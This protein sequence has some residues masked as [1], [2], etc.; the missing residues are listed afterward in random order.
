MSS[1]PTSPVR[2]LLALAILATAPACR[3]GADAA[4]ADELRQEMKALRG[5]IE[6]LNENFRRAFGTRPAAEAA[7]PPREDFDRVYSIDLAGSPVLGDPDAPVAIVEYS[8]FQCPYCARL[9]PLLE[10]VLQKYP[11]QVKLVFKHFPL[12][13]HRNARPAAQASLA[14][15]EQGKFWELHDLLFEN[16]KALDPPQIE[17]YAEQ[18]GLDIERFRRDLADNRAAYDERID[19]DLAQGQGVDV[20]G[21]PTVYIAGRKL[22]DRSV[23]GMSA[24]VERALSE[25]G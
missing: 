25:S 4:E 12:S 23:D 8:D 20:R 5:E 7:E 17:R 24:L 10:E 16:Q 2:L 11:R 22:R 9:Q 6:Q 19:A 18:V 3:P 15:G 21:T 14:A 13:F 1:I